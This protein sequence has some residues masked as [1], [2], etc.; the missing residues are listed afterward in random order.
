MYC[1]GKHLVYL[2]LHWLKRILHT[3]SILDLIDRASNFSFRCSCH[4]FPHWVLVVNVSGPNTC[5]AVCVYFKFKLYGIYLLQINQRTEALFLLHQ[6]KLQ[7][8]CVSTSNMCFLGSIL[9]RNSSLRD[10]AVS[11]IISKFPDHPLPKMLFF[12]AC[13]MNHTHFCGTKLCIALFCCHCCLSKHVVECRY[14]H[15]FIL[16]P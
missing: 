2:A 11:D 10:T 16:K 6:M 5:F 8:L 1:L 13:R 7:K 3:D 15:R 9:F 4:T 12:S 14:C